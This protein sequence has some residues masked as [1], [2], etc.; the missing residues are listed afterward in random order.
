MYLS[1]RLFIPGFRLALP[2]P[3]LSRCHPLRGSYIRE[4]LSPDLSGGAIMVVNRLYG[5]G[6]PLPLVRVISSA[7]E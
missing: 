3:R 5:S 1:D 6:M 4:R 7:K 2:P